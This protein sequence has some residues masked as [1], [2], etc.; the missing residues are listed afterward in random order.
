[1]VI[2]HLGSGYIGHDKGIPQTMIDDSDMRS[3]D[4]SGRSDQPSDR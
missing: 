4:A 1:M 3:A 2:G